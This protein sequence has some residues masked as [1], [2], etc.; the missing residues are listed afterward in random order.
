[1]IG[2]GFHVSE[3]IDPSPV[4]P[5]FLFVFLATLQGERLRKTK[6]RAAYLFPYLQDYLERREAERTNNL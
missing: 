1:M 2:F 4:H 3:G 6:T 5:Y